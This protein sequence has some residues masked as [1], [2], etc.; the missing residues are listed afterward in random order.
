MF[1]VNVLLPCE[2][3]IQNCL[4]SLGKVTANVLCA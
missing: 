4:P 3:F 2:P 1:A